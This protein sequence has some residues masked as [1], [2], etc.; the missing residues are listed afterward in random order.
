LPDIQRVPVRSSPPVRIA[1]KGFKS[2]GDYREYTLVAHTPDGECEFQFLISLGAFTD[3][4]LKLQDGPDICYRKLLSDIAAGEPLTSRKHTFVDQ[5]LAS[6][7]TATAP[8]PR[9]MSPSSQIAAAAAAEAEAVPVVEEGA[10][11]PAA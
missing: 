9:R 6:Y 8:P 11:E 4:R 1:Y 5:E 2:E 3:G 10:P 7:R